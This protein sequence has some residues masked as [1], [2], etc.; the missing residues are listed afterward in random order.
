[1]K[2]VAICTTLACLLSLNALQAHPDHDEANQATQSLPEEPKKLFVPEDQSDVFNIQ[3]DTDELG[4]EE[5]LENLEH[6]QS[7]EQAKSRPST[8]LRQN[9][10]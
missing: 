8:N 3:F 2:S 7:Q 6:I 9:N 5:E 10:P 1:M 4:Q